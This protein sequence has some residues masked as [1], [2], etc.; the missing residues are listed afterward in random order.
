MT[1]SL[2]AYCN[3][4]QDPGSLG[5]LEVSSNLLGDNTVISNNKHNLDLE[6]T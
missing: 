2:C 5:D 6:L 4:N 1:L 3:A